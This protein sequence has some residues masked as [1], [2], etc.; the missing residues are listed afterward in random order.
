MNY[1]A[2]LVVK[3]DDTV[4]HGNFGKETN[5]GGEEESVST[6]LGG[7]ERHRHSFL[8]YRNGGARME[9][10]KT[11]SAIFDKKKTRSAIL[12]GH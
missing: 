5:G 12:E 11:R 7:E 1:G 8:G 6:F 3:T 9:Q 4:K 2:T 10:K